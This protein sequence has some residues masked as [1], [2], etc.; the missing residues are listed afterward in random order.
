MGENV[1]EIQEGKLKRESGSSHYCNRAARIVPSGKAV[2]Q[3]KH[4]KLK[5]LITLDINIINISILDMKENL[6]GK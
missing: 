5:V 6:R 3:Q 4:K 2:F 1:R